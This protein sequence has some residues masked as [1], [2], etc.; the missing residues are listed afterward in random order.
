MT[1]S[2]SALIGVI[3]HTQ[4]TSKPSDQ[5]LFIVALE[6]LSASIA[7]LRHLGERVSPTSPVVELSLTYDSLQRPAGTKSAD[8]L[9]EFARA[10]GV[11]LGASASAS[12]QDDPDE[13]TNNVPILRVLPRRQSIRRPTLPIVES[14]DASTLSWMLSSAFSGQGPSGEGTAFLPPP[15]LGVTA[16]G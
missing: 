5:Q 14:L 1:Q 10:C 16:T 12:P 7:V 4:G 11:Q 8:V 6:G 13:P 15:R 3:L 2:G 9:E